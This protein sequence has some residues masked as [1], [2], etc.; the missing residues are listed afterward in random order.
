M[1][2]GRATHGGEAHV[3][4]HLRAVLLLTAL[5]LKARLENEVLHQILQNLAVLPPDLAA[6]RDVSDVIKP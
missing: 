1:G 2:G 3:L 6:Q 5:E 4:V